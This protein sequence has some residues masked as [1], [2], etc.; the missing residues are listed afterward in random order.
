MRMR[1][2]QVTCQHNAQLGRI[3]ISKR[4]AVIPLVLSVSTGS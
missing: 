3:Y 4:P 1:K 2:L